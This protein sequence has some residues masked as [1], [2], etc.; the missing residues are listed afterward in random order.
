MPKYC[1]LASLRSS[2]CLTALI[3][4]VSW[5]MLGADSHSVDYDQSVDFAALTTFAIRNDTVKSSKPELNNRLFRQ[6]LER[7]IR[8]TLTGKKL[9]ETADA[10]IVVDITLSDADFRSATR[11]PATHFPARRGMPATTIP[12]S[13]PQPELSVE[14]TLVIDIT[15][16]RSNKHIWRGT[17]RDDEPS[18]PTLSRKLSDDARKLLGEYPPHKK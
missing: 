17:Y 6:R 4:L 8:A 2:A 16:V 10:D 9:K 3:A 12:G 18:G 5:A 13:G 14:G 15:V 1:W 11:E 7:E